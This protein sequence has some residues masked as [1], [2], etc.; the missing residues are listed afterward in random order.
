MSSVCGLAQ[1]A[2]ELPLT[3]VD[4]IGGP[5]ERSFFT[6]STSTCGYTIRHD[7]LV[8]AW[9]ADTKRKI[10]Q[11]RMGGPGRLE[12]LY[13]VEF[14]SDL[15]LEYEVTDKRGDWG[16]LLRM[17][18]KTQ[19]LKWITPVSAVDLGPGLIVGNDLY[20]SAAN[21]LAKL[22]VSNGASIWQQPQPD[23]DGSF[24]LP[25]LKGDTVVF[26]DSAATGRMVE[27]DKNTGQVKKN[28][29]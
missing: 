19:K 9:V 20:F 17:D 4:R 28:S 27:V 7:G 2:T 6:F 25:T 16:Y 26:Q 18:Q 12:R 3:R 14:G 23:H 11:L 21:F 10:F 8:E 13:F 29:L 1:T 15:I 22:D 24:E 5:T